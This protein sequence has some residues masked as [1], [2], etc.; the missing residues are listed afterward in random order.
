MYQLE[1]I[2]KKMLRKLKTLLAVFATLFLAAC[3]DPCP[4]IQD[5]LN[6]GLS[7]Y[8]NC[9]LCRLFTIITAAATNAATKSWDTFHLDLI[10]LVVLASAIYIAMAV[11]KN[12]GSFGKQNAADFLTG[13]KKG[14]LILMFKTT[15]IV[16]LLQQSESNSFFINMIISPILQAGL[17]IGSTLS[18]EGAE[19]VE[20]SGT[21][22]A[23]IFDMVNEA[24]KQFN[25]QLYRTIAIGE[26]MICNAMRGTFNLF[27]WY[28]LML[29]YGFILFVFG[30]VLLVGISFYIVDILI[31]L[32]FGAILLPFG[33]AAAI[34]SLTS[35]YSKNIWS[36]F[37][38][39]FA[40]FVMLGIVLGLSIQLVN[41]SMGA[42]QSSTQSGALN[43][44]LT[45]LSANIDDNQV[46][47][48]SEELWSNGS[49]LLTIV[50]FCVIVQLTTH[51][52][53]L[54]DKIADGGSL[55]SVGSQV[56]AAVVKPVS[57]GGKRIAKSVGKMGLAAGKRTGKAFTRMT[58]LDKAYAWSG[59]KAEEI[60]GKLTGTGRQGYR[61]FWHK[62]QT[63]LADG[64]LQDVVQ[65][66]DGSTIVRDFDENHRLRNVQTVRPNGDIE[67]QSFDENGNLAANKIT[68]ADGSSEEKTFHGN[69]NVAYEKIVDTNGSSDEH[70]YDE[71][72]NLIY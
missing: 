5:Y 4:T 23:A 50:C 2:L 52:G 34:S 49:L 16:L 36:I 48:I 45:N 56:G 51:I 26:A 59:N 9:L 22:Y 37:L 1:K 39:V 57:D 42:Y 33:V 63:P 60:R 65:G 72:G 71:N 69:G 64:S 13:D 54:A 10:P 61:A 14:I 44:F 28:W 12:V 6:D 35:T 66:D 25:D 27:K 20:T 67:D 11:L 29:L 31:R 41:L 68:H 47:K 46:K 17:N 21:G 32:T 43:S 8:D 55:T 7:T 53:K 40:S 15:V 58:R 62:K 70:K 30:W 38:N 3:D 24:V 19:M 18:V